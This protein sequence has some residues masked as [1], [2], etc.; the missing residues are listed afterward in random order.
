[1]R[2]E[3]LINEHSDRLT[4][5]DMQLLSIILRNKKIIS[6][7]NSKEISDIAYTSPAGL[8]RLAKKLNFKGF[9]EFK[10]FLRQ[11]ADSIE[12]H[13]LNHTQILINDMNDTIKL[14]SQTNLNPL[15]SA[16]HSAKRIYLYG[17]DW[18][19]KRACEL[20]ARD[21]LACNILLYTI[22]SYTELQW[23]LNDITENDLLLVISFS[24]ENI[25]LNTS[26]QKLKLK[27]APYISITPLSK[28]TLSSRATYNLYYS[29]TNL[30]ITNTPDT[31]YNYFSPLEL[32]I[33]AL[34]RYYIDSY[35]E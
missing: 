21:F 34:F 9:T 5:N 32:V 6:N 15:V 18:G 17:T 22:P 8:T 16:I 27:N 26:L 1:M 13:K 24:G 12:S 25:D 3:E 2:I 31:E 28:N 19:E 30:K 14:L 35:F 7:L 10:Y 4:D 33:D 29:T 20:L 11:E 23:V